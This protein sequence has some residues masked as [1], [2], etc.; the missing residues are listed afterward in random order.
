MIPCSER[1]WAWGFRWKTYSLLGQLSRSLVLAVSQQF[2]NTTLVW[3][4]AGDFLDDLADEGGA[5]AQVALGAADARLGGDGG[6]FLYCGK[7]MVVSGF[8][9]FLLW[10]VGWVGLKVDDR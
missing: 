5:L 6:D 10:R 7:I 8:A 4:K 9:Y 3:C 1:G 2:D